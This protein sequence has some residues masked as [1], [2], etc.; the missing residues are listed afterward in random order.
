MMT[1]DRYRSIG[2][3]AGLAIGLGIMIA[4]GRGGMIAGFLFGAGGA[5]VGGIIGEKMFTRR[6]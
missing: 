5:V 4:I 1:Q 6:G 3:I 2:A